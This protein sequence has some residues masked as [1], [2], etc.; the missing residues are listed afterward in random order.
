MRR[1]DERERANKYPSKIL[2][3]KTVGPYKNIFEN[4]ILCELFSPGK[5]K[6]F[7]EN[8]FELVFLAK[9]IGNF[10]VQKKYFVNK[11]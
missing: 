5:N 9:D 8:K 11:K 3:F 2:D 4:I 10:S 7:M 1:E 6:I